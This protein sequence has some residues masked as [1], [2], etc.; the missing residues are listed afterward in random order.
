MSQL[1][2]ELTAFRV[3]RQTLSDGQCTVTLRLGELRES[4][5]GAADGGEV[6]VQSEN[7]S[8]EERKK[9]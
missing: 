3:R 1:V 8:R 6:G 2:D 7:Y 9:Q 5:D 4:E